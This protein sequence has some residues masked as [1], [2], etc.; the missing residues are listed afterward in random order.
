MESREKMEM[1][2]ESSKQVDSRGAAPL[3]NSNRVDELTRPSGAIRR[4]Q[5]L[6]TPRD[7]VGSGLLT[8]SDVGGII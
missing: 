3:E 2:S 7:T 1:R 6:H 8:T 4:D 5:S